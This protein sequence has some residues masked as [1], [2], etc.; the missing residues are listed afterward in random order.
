MDNNN[1]IINNIIY[2]K[3]G[4]KKFII[5]FNF[6]NIFHKLLKIVK[7]DIINIINY[8]VLKIKFDLNGFTINKD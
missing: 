8:I 3:I 7:N 6:N 4:F 2:D 5:Y 1:I